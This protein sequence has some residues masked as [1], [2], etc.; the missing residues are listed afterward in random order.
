MVDVKSKVQF[1]EISSESHEDYIKLL[2]SVEVGTKRVLTLDMRSQSRSNL[3]YVV[4]ESEDISDVVY[5]ATIQDLF[6]S[7]K[8]MLQEP[9]IL[10]IDS[11]RNSEDKDIID[12]VIG[13]FYNSKC[14]NKGSILALQSIK[15]ES[16]CVTSIKFVSASTKGI[17]SQLLSLVCLD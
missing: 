6:S 9:S 3:R 13:G 17:E 11:V 16:G 1:Y 12:I 7:H 4:F 8:G 2:S 15:D 10:P 14:I 5:Y